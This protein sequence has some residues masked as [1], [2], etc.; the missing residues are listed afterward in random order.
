VRQHAE[1]VAAVPM[2]T[3][4]GQWGRR[5][6]SLAVIKRRRRRVHYT[7]PVCCVLGVC[8]STHT[9]GYTRPEPYPRVQVRSGRYLTGRVGYD[10]QGYWYTRFYQKGTRFFKILEWELFY[11]CMFL[12]L[13]MV[14]ELQYGTWKQYSV[15]R[16]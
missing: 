10:V 12:K 7:H 9:R 11:F 15:S 6:S 16:L 1:L 4:E 2:L 8:G 5:Y 14:K 3:L 13:L